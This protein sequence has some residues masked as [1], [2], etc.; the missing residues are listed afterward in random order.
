MGSAVRPRI[1]LSS[2]RAIGQQIFVR[3]LKDRFVAGAAEEAAQ[4]DAILGGA[5]RKFRADEGAGGQALALFRGNQ[6]PESGALAVEF[7]GLIDQGQG[8]RGAVIDA[9]EQPRQVG[10]D[11]GQQ[12]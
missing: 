4:H 10:I 9:R 11:A 5:I 12:R 2:S 1:R 3:F 7:G 6:K 8:Q